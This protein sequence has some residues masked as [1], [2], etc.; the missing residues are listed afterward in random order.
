MRAFSS[1]QIAFLTGVCLAT[2]Q[3]LADDPL[4]ST[5]LSPRH[6]LA[7][8]PES[9]SPGKEPT[10]RGKALRQWIILAKD[11]HTSVQREATEVLE[12]IGPM[13]IPTLV[14][15][16]R[17]EDEEGRRLVS[18]AL[19]SIGKDALP[20]IAESLRNTNGV[21]R[22][23][24]VALLWQIDP[25]ST[26]ATTAVSILPKSLKD[27]D[28]P[29]RL[30]A[31]SALEQIGP[32]AKT[33]APLLAEALEDRDGS[34]RLAAAKALLKV[35]PNEAKVA[36]RCIIKLLRHEDG[37]VRFGAVWALRGI[38]LAG[39]DAGLDPYPP[40]HPTPALRD[41]GSESVAALTEALKDNDG[42]VREVAASV[43]G[44]IGLDVKTTVPAIVEL[45]RDSDGQVRKAAA[46]ALGKM[47]VE[48]KAA[49]PALTA[50]LKDNDGQ[51]REA[52]AEALQKM[53]PKAAPNPVSDKDRDIG[54]Y[55]LIQ[56]LE[57]P[58]ADAIKAIPI[59]T[60][61]LKADDW[62]VRSESASFLGNIGAEAK[63]AIP[64]L[65]ELLNDKDGR[66][67]WAAVSALGKIG[68]V[69]RTAVPSLTELLKDK[70]GHVRRAAAEACG[71]MGSEAKTAIPALSELLKDEDG[72]VRQAATDA[73]QKIQ[74]EKR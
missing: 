69:A 42:R 19:A 26:E 17:K 15:L 73:L 32:Q 24:T 59:V 41:L 50:S 4:A 71:E 21:V 52:A 49:M 61:L 34:V 9:T 40:L 29:V 55:A 1:L 28:V 66:V 25:E 65:T 36:I 67:R 44:D 54:R 43:L 13:A 18:L 2:G 23:E 8:D 45:L 48:A 58:G 14:Q 27:Q 37:Y 64:V 12:N 5:P 22:C 62:F 47:G 31:A 53:A 60:K 51:V 56:S 38:A 39:R 74:G 57:R 63:A 33:V 72:Q 11:K 30:A 3:A 7:A 20:A 10:Y 6:R 16:L 70:D 68:A 35:S 46:S